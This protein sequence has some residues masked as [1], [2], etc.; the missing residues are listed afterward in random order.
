M[1]DDIYT[2]MLNIRYKG[3]YRMEN[4]I[5]KIAEKGTQETF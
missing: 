3:E 1:I 2:E 5:I 4:K